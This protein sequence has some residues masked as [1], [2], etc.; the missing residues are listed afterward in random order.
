MSSAHITFIDEARA[1]EA[2]R[3]GWLIREGIQYHWF[4]RGYSSFDDFLGALTSRKRKAIRKERAPGP[5]GAAVRSAARRR[6]RPGRMGRDVGNSTRTPAAR[7]WGHPYL[8]REFFD[9]IGETH[10]RQAAVVSRLPRIGQPIA[11]ALNFI[12]PDTLY[13]RYWG[14]IEEVPFLHFELCY[15]Q[16]IEWAIDAWPRLRSGRCPGRAQA[17]ARL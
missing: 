4:N 5:Q 14:C 6:D 9:L 1:A 17:R 10:G 11:G 3:R 7:K 2:E 16:A 13:G 12:G 8:T 15:Y